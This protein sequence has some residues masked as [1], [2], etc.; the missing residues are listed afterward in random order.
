MAFSNYRG[1]NIKLL[2]REKDLWQVQIQNKVLQGQLVGVRKSIDWFCDSAS[3]IDPSE[4][5][6][7]ANKRPVVKGSVDN[8]HGFLLQNDS[9]EYNAWYCM[10]K[11]RLIKGTNIALKKHIRETIAAINKQRAALKVKN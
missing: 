5:S 8:F 2:N 9:G 11:G 4:F 10:F 7:L 6:S 1:F 3:I